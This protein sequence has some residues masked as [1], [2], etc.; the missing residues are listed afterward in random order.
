MRYTEEQFNQKFQALSPELQTLIGSEDVDGT[1]GDIASDHSFTPEQHRN[2][3]AEVVYV[4]LGLEQSS[5]FIQNLVQF[6]G[7]SQSDAEK[8]ATQ[9][10]E[11]IFFKAGIAPEDPPAPVAK[12][13]VS[14]PVVEASKSIEPIPALIPEAPVAAAH[15]I[16]I[17]E[18]VKKPEPQPFIEEHVHE[19]LPA[20]QEEREVAIR[21]IVTPDPVL[22][23]QLEVPVV[24]NN[25]SLHTAPV[26]PAFVPEKPAVEAPKPQP[27]PV[28]PPTPVVAP[29]SNPTPSIVDARLGI[30]PVSMPKEDLD[31][32]KNKKHDGV[33]YP[34]RYTKDP[35][36][37]PIE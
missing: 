29:T 30:K 10:Q 4:I 3:S 15:P 35:Y 37:E 27:I 8:I 22:N 13:L 5:A 28:I 24:R 21:R 31:L 23:K 34:P 12:T 25:E 9:V 1:I 17:I 36:R 20:I 33:Q 16:N 32:S 2:F 18:E 11:E 7:I 26:T 6:I 14:Q 19:N